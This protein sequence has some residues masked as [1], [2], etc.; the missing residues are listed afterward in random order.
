MVTIFTKLA[1]ISAMAIGTTFGLFD[2]DDS[3][4]TIDPTSSAC[5]YHQCT[6]NPEGDCNRSGRCCSQQCNNV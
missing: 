2:L 4:C 3:P 6:H 5:C 1:I